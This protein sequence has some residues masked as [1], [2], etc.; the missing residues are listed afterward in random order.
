MQFVIQPIDFDFRLKKGFDKVKAETM[1]ILGDE[2]STSTLSK[3][4][5]GKHD[6][7]CDER[8]IFSRYTFYTFTADDLDK[9][10]NPD[11][12]SDLVLPP[13]MEDLSKY[14]KTA[15]Y[16]I[17]Q[18]EKEEIDVEYFADIC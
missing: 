9:E 5:Y 16:L 6:G 12:Q 7:I 1:K 17:D 2:L 4:K 8:A 14:V 3:D 11:L 15:Y 18:I 10:K 13:A